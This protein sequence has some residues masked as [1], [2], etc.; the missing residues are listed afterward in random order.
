MTA[1]LPH[2]RLH[3][4]SQSCV[5]IS[6]DPMRQRLLEMIHRYEVG[7]RFQAR[8]ANLK[9]QAVART[10]TVEPARIEEPASLA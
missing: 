3:D 10:Q 7:R 4:A 5:N 8:L 6:N 9:L 1:K 2:L